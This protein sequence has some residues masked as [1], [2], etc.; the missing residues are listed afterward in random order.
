MC[1]S[2]SVF[3]IDDEEAEPPEIYIIRKKTMRPDDD[4]D[5]AITESYEYFFYLRRCLHTG[6]YGYTDSKR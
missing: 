5:G 6:Q 3:L 1:D 4:I 2:E